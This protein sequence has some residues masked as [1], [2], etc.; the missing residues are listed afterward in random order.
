[1]PPFK[2]AG[3]AV[4]EIDVPAEGTCARE[5]H[6]AKIASGD[7]VAVEPARKAAKAAPVSED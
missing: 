7:L 4:F 3:G 5:L 1:M 2:G 6:D